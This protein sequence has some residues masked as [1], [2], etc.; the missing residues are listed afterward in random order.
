MQLSLCQKCYFIK[1]YKNAAIYDLNNNKVYSINEY[2]KYLID[3][4]IT[5]TN[6]ALSKKDLEYLDKLKDLKLLTE[7]INYNNNL[8]IERNS[9]GIEFAWL[10]LTDLCNLRCIHCYGEFGN[11]VINKS[12]ILSINDWKEIIDKLLDIDC[13]NIQLIGGEPLMH[14]D[15]ME[16]LDYSHKKGFKRI[17]LFTNGTLIDETIAK[18]LGR[19]NINVRVSVYGHNPVVHDSITK[20]NGS[21]EK[22]RR[23]LELLKKY[24]VNTSIAII[25]MKEN[26]AYLDEIKKYIESIGHKYSGYDV[27]RPTCFESHQK[28]AI[29]NINIL[30]S[31][32]NTRPVFHTSEKDFIR[33]HFYNS[34][35]N[36]KIAITSC[37]DVLPCIF[38]RNDIVGNIKADNEDYLKNE[39]I[40]KWSITKDN[41]EVC[42]DCEYRY[43]CHDCRPLAIGI[44]GN[45]FSKYPRCCYNPYTG[46]WEEISECTKE[47]NNKSNKMR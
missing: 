18:K 44:Y 32:Y 39:I 14:K 5:N 46:I 37:G 8:L 6:I 43:C 30:K 26:E 11:S 28:H 22:N 2:G 42:K 41:I 34:C 35:W 12:R 36:G 1:G 3:A 13:K 7:N 40:K 20:V 29:S 16:I 23:G 9:I 15:F 33:N 25:I 19:Y 45:M 47:L 31:R 4:V 17:D 10:E 27:V 38:S 21:F 24:S